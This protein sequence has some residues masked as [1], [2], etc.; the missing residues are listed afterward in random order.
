MAQSFSDSS[1]TYTVPSAYTT[2]TVRRSFSGLASNGVLLLIGEAD[3]GPDFTQEEDLAANSFSPT[4]EDAVLAKYK[5][6]NLVDAFRAAVAPANDEDISGSFTQIV[7]MKTNVAEKA[8]GTLTSLASTTYGSLYDKS[9]GALGNLIYFKVIENTAEAMPTTGEFAYIPAVGTTALNFRISGQAVVTPSNI[10][11]NSMPSSFV[12]TID[13]LAGIDATGGALRTT[14][15]GVSGNLI[16]TV[17]SVSNK[18][19]KITYSS[20]WTTTP[21]VGDTLVIPTGSPIAATLA[22]IGGYIVTAATSSTVTA[23]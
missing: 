16:V 19:I 1:G 13:A 17:T 6:G 2:Y 7:L 12:S 4:E 21:S 23:R 14:I 22:N 10:S 3:A 9:Y 20:T 18:E 15:P 11:A 5:S 8:S